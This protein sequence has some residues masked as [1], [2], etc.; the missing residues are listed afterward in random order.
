MNRIG[1]GG[2]SI[3][4]PVVKNLLIINGLLFLGTFV[5]ESN[6]GISLIRI[7]G[8]HFFESEFFQ[9]FQLVTHMFM[10]GG[11]L[12]IFSNMFALW[13]FGSTLENV[14]GPK[15]FLFFYFFTGLGAAAL[16]M[17]VTAY[18]LYSLQNAVEMYIQDPSFLAFRELVQSHSTG[19]MRGSVNQF[20]ANWS[21]QP[22]NTAYIQRSVSLAQELYSANVNIPT[23][24]ASGAVFGI[25]L[26]FGMLFPN[27]RLFLLFPPIPIKAKYFV[28]F[29][30]LFELYAGFSS[31]SGGSNIAH[32]AHLG[33]MLFGFILIKYWNKSSR[34]FF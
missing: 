23:V 24:G 26:G 10:H 2:F 29:Y 9:P 13:M 15:R 32:F 30:G 33:G 25:L 34:N 28:I 8:L 17:G 6:F 22:D 12:H 4:P 31:F 1:P 27:T 11:M 19:M 16:H 7:L 21:M 3:L 18:S 14:W 20:L 5:F